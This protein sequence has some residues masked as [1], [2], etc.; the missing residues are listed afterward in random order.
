MYG[1]LLQLKII[2]RK[3]VNKL[4]LIRRNFRK[5]NAI[6][7]R[8]SNFKK[9]VTEQRLHFCNFTSHNMW[10][11]QGEYSVTHQ[12][13]I[14]YNPPEFLP[15]HPWVKLNSQR[16]KVGGWG[17]RYD[18]GSDRMWW[19]FGQQLLSPD[20]I[21]VAHNWCEDSNQHRQYVW[22]HTCRCISHLLHV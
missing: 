18:L 22:R 16:S 2:S 10:E 4:L 5:V 1:D 19:H 7:K 3:S 6:I 15:K 9:Y 13:Q 14:F 8:D 12:H 11:H 17:D 20:I 21:T